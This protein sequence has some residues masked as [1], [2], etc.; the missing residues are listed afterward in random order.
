MPHEMH[1]GDEG[2]LRVTFS[3]DFDEADVKAFARDLAP[4]L[5]AAEGNIH[6]LV[7]V[8]RADKASTG[9]R[10]IFREMFRNPDPH[11]GYT[12]MVGA[13][14]YIRVV[15]GFVMQITGTADTLRMFDGEEEALAWLQ[16]QREG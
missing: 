11:T 3:G 6:L 12:A 8:H 15:V 7:D 13:S 14:R 16:A 10:Q 2:I 1:L 4:I 9:A 5:A